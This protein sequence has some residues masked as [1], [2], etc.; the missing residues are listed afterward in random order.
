MFSCMRNKK[1][2]MILFISVLACGSQKTPP[3]VL[4]TAP[5]IEHV[6]GGRCTYEDYPS[7]CVYEGNGNAT[8]VGTINGEDVSFAGNTIS[9]DPN[10]SEPAIGAEIPCTISYITQGTCTPCL[11]DVGSCGT[12]A[13]D[14]FA[15]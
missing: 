8:L 5:N 12:E 3:K 13:F 2:M 11:L 7:V 10:H 15:H 14:R 6:D 4:E 9:F 1:N